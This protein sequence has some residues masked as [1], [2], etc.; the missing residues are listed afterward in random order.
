MNFKETTKMRKL[1]QGLDYYA[2]QVFNNLNSRK[3][4]MAWLGNS[5]SEPKATYINQ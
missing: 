2:P 3:I 5:Q 4:T 1:D